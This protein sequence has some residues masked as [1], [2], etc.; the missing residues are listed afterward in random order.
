MTPPIDK[1][2]HEIPTREL[3]YLARIW[4][5]R[6]ASRDK[7]P[8]RYDKL[9]AMYYRAMVEIQERAKKKGRNTK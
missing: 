4:G 8:I 7:T 3:T 9:A 1:R 2:I 5:R 6:M